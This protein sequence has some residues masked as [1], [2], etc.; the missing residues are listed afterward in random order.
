LS[1]AN[2]KVLA[3]LKEKAPETTAETRSETN[4]DTD[5]RSLFYS[6]TDSHSIL[7]GNHYVIKVDSV[8]RCPVFESNEAHVYDIDSVLTNFYDCSDSETDSDSDSECEVE[9]EDDE[10]ESSESDDEIGDVAQENNRADADDPEFEM[11][12]DPVQ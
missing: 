5:A 2:P 11:I 1:V 6:L 4:T 9:I 12:E 8:L 7:I 10:S 3:A